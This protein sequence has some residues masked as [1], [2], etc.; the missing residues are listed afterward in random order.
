MSAQLEN[1]YT[2]IANEILDQLY[3]TKLNGTQ[4]RI[5]MLV[6]RQTYGFSRKSHPISQETISKLTGISKRQIQR[7]LSFLI[8]AKIIL[9]Y[10]EATFSTPA[11]IGFNKHFDDWCLDCQEVTKKTPVDHKDTT[12]DGELVTS[13]D[14]ILDTSTDGEL[15]VPPISA[16]RS[17]WEIEAL[18]SEAK[19]N[20][21][22]SIKE[23]SKESIYSLIF[24][25]WNAHGIIVHRSLDEKTKRKIKVALKTRSPD[26]IIN[27]IDT[28][29]EIVLG[30]D[31]FFEYKWTLGDFLT[32]GL[33]QFVIRDVA[34]NNY[35]TNDA[36]KK[37]KKVVNIND[38][39]KYRREDYRG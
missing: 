34:I 23:N 5:L 13:T 19:E 30:E 22:E 38:A 12:T 11:T 1:G 24:E 21:K 35:L 17:D 6:F 8:N 4:F 15:V 31:Y 3:I 29:A 7:E 26:E 2:R 36:R 10:E 32:R 20:F 14:D 33:E 27:A 16:D 9:V 37:Q 28:Y 39:D 18:F 25:H